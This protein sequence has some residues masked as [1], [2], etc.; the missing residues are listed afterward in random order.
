MVADLSDDFAVA[1]WEALDDIVAR[2]AGIEQRK[3]RMELW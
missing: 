1:Y 2:D 3:F